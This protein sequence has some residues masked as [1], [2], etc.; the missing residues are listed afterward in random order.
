M[1]P[2]MRADA[3]MRLDPRNSYVTGRHS[4][5]LRPWLPISFDKT[6]TRDG[7]PDTRIFAYIDLQANIRRNFIDFDGITR[8]RAGKNYVSPS[9]RIGS[10]F[11]F[12]N[13]SHTIR[14]SY[15]L[16]G[17]SIDAF[18]LIGNVVFD[19]DPLNRRT[20]NPDLSQTVVH[21]VNLFYFNSNWMLDRLKMYVDLRY[22]VVH[23]QTAMSYAYD[24]STGVRTY[25]PV[26]VDGNRYGSFV[27][28][29]T[30]ALT[31]DKKLQLV[32]YLKFE[33]QRSVDMMSYD[34]FSTTQKS[35]V[36]SLYI[37]EYLSLQYN[38]KKFMAAFDGQIETRR[39]S[40]REGFFN[41]F[42]I[43]TYRYGVRGRVSL[44]AGFEI[45]TDLK[46]YS[47][48][49]FDYHEMNTNQLVWNGRITKTLLAGQLMLS[50]DGYD[51]LGNV[52]NISYKVNE[53]G[54]TETWVNNIP[55]YL[56]LSLRWNFAK[57]PR[58]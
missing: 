16:Q 36:N 53:Q 42:R 32:D 8:V 40:S 41:P 34:A 24:R 43:T 37:S 14:F 51:I 21:D 11:D 9:V 1:L 38:A 25:R 20:G 47:T 56:M 49:G 5:N 26:N 2:S 30:V 10:T 46:M 17:S 31:R 28:G 15:G 4:T 33:P 39:T 18:D 55:S 52:K 27:V 29:P 3:M 35:I 48:R 22:T 7:V 13:L 50:L 23:N 12:H 19:S 45:S 57:K 58:E 44:P 54:R 6:N